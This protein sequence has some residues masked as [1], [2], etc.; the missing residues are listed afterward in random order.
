MQNEL[1]TTASWRVDQRRSADGRAAARSIAGG[2]RGGG[3]RRRARREPALA[4]RTRRRLADAGREPAPLRQPAPTA[5]APAPNARGPAGPERATVA[6][7]AAARPKPRRRRAEAAAA[8]PRP[9]ASRAEAEPKK[10]TKREA[11]AGASATP[12]PGRPSRSPRSRAPAAPPSGVPPVLIP[13]YQRAAAAYGLGPQGPAVLAGI[14]EIETAFGTNLNVSSAGAVG[15]MQ[16]MPSTWESY[17]VDANGDGVADP[18]NPED[19]IFAAARY[20]QRRRD[21]GRHLRRDLR[22]QP[23]RLVRRRG[24]RQRRLLR[25]RVGGASPAPSRSTPQL[26]GAQLRPGRGLARSGSPPT[27]WTPSRA[28]PAATNS[29]GAA[30]GRWPRSPGSSR[31]SAAG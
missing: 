29:A 17:G 14:N 13:I 22:L 11:D 20:L 24:A 1:K 30:S 15:W 9:S 19:A 21:A 7:A 12:P 23:R 25:R 6:A 18:Y 2:R 3:G 26:A 4:G 5:A 8:R 27:T 28:P 31:T 16:F 10:P